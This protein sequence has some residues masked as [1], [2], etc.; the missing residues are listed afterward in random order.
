MRRTLGIIKLQIFHRRKRRLDAEIV[1]LTARI[2]D[3]GTKGDV[4]YVWF[5]V[6]YN[7][8]EQVSIIGVGELLSGR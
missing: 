2:G 7:T 6:L 4:S 5:A 8:Q 1:S 3:C